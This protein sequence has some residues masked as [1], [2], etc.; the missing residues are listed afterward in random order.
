MP[1][2]RK[3]HAAR[4]KR[5]GLETPNEQTMKLNLRFRPRL[6][7]MSRAGLSPAQRRCLSPTFQRSRAE[8]GS[9]AAP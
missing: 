1:T 2:P 5:A 6:A 7:A 9:Q 8:S 4:A 3:I